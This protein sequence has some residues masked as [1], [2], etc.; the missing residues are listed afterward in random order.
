MRTWLGTRFG[1][2]CVLVAVCLVVML[3]NLGTP[4]L[5]D[6]DEGVNAECSREMQEVGTWL[7]PT[8][9]YELRTAKPVMLY[10]L[11]RIAFEGF[12]VSEWS[13]RFPAVLCGIGSV[14]TTAALA[15]RMFGAATGLLAGIILAT[16]IQFAILSHAATPD[17][18]LIFFVTLTFYLFWMGHTNH[19]RRW[20]LTAPI[21]CA[22]AILTKGPAYL[23]LIGLPILLYFVWTHQWRRLGDRRLIWGFLILLAIAVPWYAAVA[24]ETRGVF[25]KA[26]I[27][28]E[29]INRMQGAMEGHDGRPFYQAYYL[30]MILILFAPWSVFL[31]GTFQ[32]S[33][34]QARRSDDTAEPY[35]LL[36]CWLGTI[37]LIT[38]IMATK[39]PNYIAT[40]YPALAILTANFLTRWRMNEWRVPS[41]MMPTAAGI[42]VA[43]GVLVFFGFL[44]AAG[45]IPVPGV[46]ILPALAPYA[47]LGLCFTIAG[48][49]MLA[50]WQHQNRG[51]YLAALVAG[52]IA[53]VSLTAAFAVVAVD[54]SKAPRELVAMSGAMIHDRDVAI[55][56]YD[57][58]QPSV[59]F[60]VQRK[61]QRLLDPAQIVSFFSKERPA[62]LFTTIDKWPMI[63]KLLSG[64]VSII[65]QR[66]DFYR[67]QDVIVISNPRP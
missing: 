31:L 37:L 49:G 27:G 33:L 6:V 29:N 55:A 22:L 43:I 16:S 65:A 45:T 3:P 19:S 11:Q 34:A 23:G 58:T 57:Y 14:L 12:G 59:T 63:E 56:S 62:Y 44:I 18:P 13:A 52:T 28:N 50:S 10:W 51:A 36:L 24:A 17:A 32:H 67:H 53:F 41:W 21:P 47:G 40:L 26:F 4:S 35:R 60:Y 7:I 66:Y 8:F 54:Q 61:V 46:Q 25:I 39:L 42:V 5:W 2:Q 30:V 15:R 48:V 9:N 64:Q 38:S 1:H 20:F